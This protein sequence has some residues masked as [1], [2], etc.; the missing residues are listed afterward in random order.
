MA[1]KVPSVGKT[2]I[3]AISTVAKPEAA[4]V[5]SQKLDLNVWATPSRKS[6]NGEQLKD[7]AIQRASV[8]TLGDQLR[9]VKA[10]PEGIGFYKREELN[11]KASM[12][13]FQSSSPWD[14]QLHRYKIARIYMTQKKHVHCHPT[15]KTPG[16]GWT[17][18]FSHWGNHKSPLMGWSRGT[19]DTMYNVKMNFGRLSDAID[20]A[21]VMGWGYDVM[22][23]HYRWHTKKDYASNFAWKGPPKAEIDYD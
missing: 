9:Y 1:S 20:Y 11:V 19:A 14:M 6:P 3:T 16:N 22:H 13:S 17:I 21:T 7:G 12:G 15:D 10:N 18:D 5:L 23:P 2:A 4:A 8:S